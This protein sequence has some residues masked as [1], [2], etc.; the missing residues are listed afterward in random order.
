M[1]GRQRR[2]IASGRAAGQ[3][4]QSLSDGVGHA[5]SLRGTGEFWVAEPRLAPVAAGG[6]RGCGYPGEAGTARVWSRYGVA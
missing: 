5:P 1:Q 3:I 4:D 6:A 2:Q